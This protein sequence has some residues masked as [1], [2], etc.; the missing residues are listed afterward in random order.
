MYFHRSKIWSTDLLA[1]CYLHQARHNDFAS[2][3]KKA[4]ISA[5]QMQQKDEI[6]Y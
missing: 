5:A 2:L 4:K 1:L 6:E 3:A